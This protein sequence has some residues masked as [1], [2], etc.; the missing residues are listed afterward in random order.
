MDAE[1]QFGYDTYPTCT[2]GGYF[3][4][5]CTNCSYHAQSFMPK[6][7]HNFEYRPYQGYYVCKRCGAIAYEI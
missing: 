6:L 5:D 1:S 7:G 2:E 3:V 4:R